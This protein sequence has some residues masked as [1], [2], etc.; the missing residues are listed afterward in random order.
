MGGVLNEYSVNFDG[1]SYAW[2][3]LNID[4]LEVLLRITERGLKN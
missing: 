1:A 4:D 2:G 3:T